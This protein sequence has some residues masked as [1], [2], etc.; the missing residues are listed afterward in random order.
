MTRFAFF[1][2]IRQSQQRRAAR[3]RLARRRRRAAGTTQ[4]TSRLSVLLLSLPGLAAIAA[5]LFTWLQ[6][7]QSGKEL[8]IIEDQQIT[9]RFNTAIGNLS[10]DSVDVRMGGIFA[11]ERIMKDSAADQPTIVSV[12]CAYVRR[13]AP[14]PRKAP[15]ALDVYAAMDVLA[16]R[17]PDHDKGQHLYLGRTDLRDWG[18]VAQPVD[19]AHLHEAWLGGADLRGVILNFADLGAADLVGANLTKAQI[20]ASDLTDA[21]LERARL[22]SADFTKANLTRAWLCNYE[23]TDSAIAGTACADM[24]GTNFSGADLAEAVLIGADLRKANLCER[25][26]FIVLGEDGDEQEV[27]CAS[28]RKADLTEANLAGLDLH[29]VDLSNAVL[30][31]ANLT[32]ADLRGAKLSG[33]SLKH[34]VTTGTTGLPGVQRGSRAPGRE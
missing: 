4:Q 11:L 31:Y 6:V 5:L 27:G 8:K 16:R 26:V 19:E 17:N 25:G 30:D 7:S 34:A 28:L 13:N 9:A 22:N 32:N 23:E 21:Y 24:N 18:A 15:P 10:S 2:T 33:A 12:L 20:I 14:L 29:G 1:R 3:R